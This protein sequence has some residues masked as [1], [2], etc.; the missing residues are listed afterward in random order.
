M[1]KQQGSKLR[2]PLEA[3]ASGF[4]DLLPKFLVPVGSKNLLVMENI[5]PSLYFEI[6][7]QTLP[8]QCRFLKAILKYMVNVT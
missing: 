6:L 4:W 1:Y 7:Q 8:M 2:A 3:N 5:S